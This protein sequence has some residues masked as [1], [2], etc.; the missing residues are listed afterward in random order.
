[1]AMGLGLIVMAAAKAAG[2]GANLDELADCVRKAIPRSH[3]VIYFDTLKYL[4]KGGRIGKA[5]GLMGAMLSIKPILTIKDGEM[6]PL[7]RV[8]SPAAGLDYLYNFVPGFSKIEALAVEHATTPDEADELVERLSAIFPKEQIYRAI[9]SPVLG[10]HAG[11]N[12][13]A[14]TVL[15]AE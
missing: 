1:V 15:E 3:L 7:T 13:L 4:A 6:A 8:R 2:A 12:A 14:L 10:T 9:V 11:P 5:Q